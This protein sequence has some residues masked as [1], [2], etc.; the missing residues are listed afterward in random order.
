M[1]FCTR[2][3]LSSYCRGFTLVELLV[4]IA[5][6]GILV[7]LLLPAVQAA[8]ESARRA[9]CINNLKQ[10]GISAHL[11]VDAHGFF[12]SSGWGDWWVGCPDQ[13]P[14]EDQ[15]GSWAY[16]LLPFIEETARAQVG[17]GFTCGDPNS[18]AAIGQMVATAVST[19]YCPS[20]RAPQAYPWVNRSNT[21]FDPPELAGKSDYACNAG[22]LLSP[23]T[24]VGPS[25]L[26]RAA[27]Y[28]WKYINGQTGVVYQRS[29]I[30]FAQIT[31]GSTYTY[32]FGEKNLN[33]D[34]YLTGLAGNDD[35]SM[36]NGH[37]RDNIRYTYV[38]VHAPTGKVF[39]HP[40]T[41]DTPGL[42]FT[43][44]FGG[45]HPGVWIPLY[46]DGSVRTMSYDL[47]P[48]IH[49]WLGNRNDGNTIDTGQ[50]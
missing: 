19:F 1:P 29:E 23:G 32:L 13:G 2:V 26:D 24:D 38:Q 46:C 21:N 36:Y 40:L 16:Q 9:Q 5:I 43:W 37:D 4:V 49:R 30:K 8:R 27:T 42:E 18:R 44:N 20:R 35:Q 31:D 6:I 12:P 47:Y 50:L 41:P 14:G 45:P 11:H 39:G 28:R 15:P 34:Q 25:S 10:L 48:E 7:A 33:P 22:D 3:R 17:Q